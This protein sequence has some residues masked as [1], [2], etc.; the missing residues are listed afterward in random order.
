M[1]MESAPLSPFLESEGELDS[2]GSF[3]RTSSSSSS[4][5]V[6]QS[7][8]EYY[9]VKVS[10]LDVNKDLISSKLCEAA[11]RTIYLFAASTVIT[12]LKS[13]V[14]WSWVSLQSKTVDEQ[15]TV[16]LSNMF[17]SCWS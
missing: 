13:G 4:V 8:C 6:G 7:G 10:V 17:V 9:R 12:G 11:S 14:S 16:K 2:Q 3:H 5:S 15:L 1:V